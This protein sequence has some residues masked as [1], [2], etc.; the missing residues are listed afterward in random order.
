[1]DSLTILL[2]E[3]FRK[4]AIQSRFCTVEDLDRAERQF[5][6]TTLDRFMKSVWLILTYF[7]A[8]HVDK[9]NP[10]PPLNPKQATFSAEVEKHFDNRNDDIEIVADRLS[11]NASELEVSLEPLN[12][13]PEKAWLLAS[14]LW[15]LHDF[16]LIRLDDKPPYSLILSPSPWRLIPKSSSFIFH[17]LILF[18]ERNRTLGAENRALQTRGLAFE[19]YVADRVSGTTLIKPET[20]LAEN[21]RGKRPDYI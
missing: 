4:I 6:G 7:G 17:D 21:Y 5:L 13:V 15:T 9:R 18:Y 12:S 11:I 14:E 2:Y 20:L 8:S 16:P 10:P 19:S 3:K 1:M